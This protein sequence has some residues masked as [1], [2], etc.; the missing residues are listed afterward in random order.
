MYIYEIG[1]ISKYF[2]DNIQEKAILWRQKLDEFAHDNN[3]KT[4][5]PVLTY[6]KEINHSYDHT[7]CVN[8]NDYYINK[9]DIAIANMEDIDFS[10]GS[11]YEL[12]SFKRLG[13]P[14]IA[15]SATKHWSPHINS[16]ISQWCNTLKETI[17]VLCNMF[18]QNE[19]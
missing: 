3:I 12:V 9:C 7:L 2:R 15:F 19:F 16:C 8:Q 14:V 13:K 5:N 18:N 10:P 17:Q 4:F 6:L 1:A 11:L